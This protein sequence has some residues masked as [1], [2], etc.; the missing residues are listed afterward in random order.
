MYLWGRQEGGKTGKLIGE[1][2]HWE[3]SLEVLHICAFLGP[4]VW[5]CVLSLLVCVCVCACV[6]VCVCVCGCE[7]V[8]VFVCSCL[9]LRV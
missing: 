3:E 7:C 8:R 4:Y 9:Y 6:C 5:S 1:G 2:V